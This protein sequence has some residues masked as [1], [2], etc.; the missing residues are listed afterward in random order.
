MFRLFDLVPLFVSLFGSLLAVCRPVF[1]ITRF[2][3][4]L[5]LLLLGGKL[6]LLQVLWVI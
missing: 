1:L 3:S 6:L 5:S 2:I 4:R